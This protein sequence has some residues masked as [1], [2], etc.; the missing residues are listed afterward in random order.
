MIAIATL[1]H[2][3]GLWAYGCGTVTQHA[4]SYA[5]C[6]LRLDALRMDPPDGRDFVAGA[7]VRE[8]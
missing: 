6:L 3:L 2:V 5:D 8:G 1:C 4:A 7:C